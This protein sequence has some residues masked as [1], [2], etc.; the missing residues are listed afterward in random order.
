M[1]LRRKLE[2]VSELLVS[3]NIDGAAELLHQIIVEKACAIYENIVNDEEESE[4]DLEEIGGDSGESFT[5]KIRSDKED[6]DT[7]EQNDGELD[8]EEE[9]EDDD[10]NEDFG[11][12]ESDVDERLDDL[13]NQLEELRAE[14]DD[15]M[16]EELEEPEHADL[17]D[18]YSEDEDEEDFE[19]ESEDDFEEPED[20]SDEGDDLEDDSEES[21]QENKNAAN[22]YERKSSKK[23]KVAPQ[24]KDKKKDKKVD[25]ETQFWTRVSDTGQTGTAKLVGTGN[26][27]KIGAEHSKSLYSNAPAKKDYGG[28]PVQISKGTGGEYGKYSHGQSAKKGSDISN[29][30]IKP[31]SVTAKADTTDKYTGGKSAPAGNRKSPVASKK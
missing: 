7:D 16:D 27:S 9:E 31:K 15:L 5:D 28:K 25:E 4:D 30:S 29:T 24:S 12:E 23:L 21:F 10:F 1:S 17:A 26:K 22:V 20:F 18:E 11:D 8:D 2:K 19:D 3:E 6:I 14:F 13:E